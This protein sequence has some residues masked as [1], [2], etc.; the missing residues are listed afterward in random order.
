VNPHRSYQDDKWWYSTPDYP[1]L[2]RS[3]KILKEV[4]EVKGMKKVK[5]VKGMKEVKGVKGVKEVKA[6]KVV[7]RSGRAPNGYRSPL[8]PHR[9]PGLGCHS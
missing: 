5:K 9:E 3:L 8:Q 7:N 1:D 4:K 2:H 6:L